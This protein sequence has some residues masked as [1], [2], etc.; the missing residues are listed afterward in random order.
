MAPIV[1]IGQNITYSE[2]ASDIHWTII[3]DGKPGPITK[4]LMAAFK[5]YVADPKNSYPI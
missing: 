4:K 3:G 1:K 5:E 2:D